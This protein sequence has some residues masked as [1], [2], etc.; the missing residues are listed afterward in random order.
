MVPFRFGDKDESAIE[1]EFGE[2]SPLVKKSFKTNK[3]KKTQHDYEMLYLHRGDSIPV[4]LYSAVPKFI[5]T[6]INEEQPQKWDERTYYLENLEEAQG[7]PDAAR[8][9]YTD[10]KG[11]RAVISLK[12]FY[13]MMARGGIEL[14]MVKKVEDLFYGKTK[15]QVP[16]F[17]TAIREACQKA[18]E[19]AEARDADT[20]TGRTIVDD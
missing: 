20:I 11:N 13:V 14:G 16:P 1:S 5:D 4:Q 7:D 9:V 6:E 17:I 8:Y 15:F 2:N 18:L 19:Q 10:D 3:R 12:D